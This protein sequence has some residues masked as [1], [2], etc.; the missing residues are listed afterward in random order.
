MP[1]KAVRS[2]LPFRLGRGIIYVLPLRSLAYAAIS[3]AIVAAVLLAIDRLVLGS[4]ERGGWTAGELW[5]RH[6]RL[7]EENTRRKTTSNECALRH[8]NGHPLAATSG[9]SRRRILVIGDSFVWGPAY[10]TLNHLWWRQLAIELERRGYRDVEV[11]AVG[12][13]GWSTRRQLDCARQT[14]PAVK[15]DLVIWG[16]V[17]NDPD[18]KLIPQIFDLQN[19][20][21]I[22]DRV[23]R[24]LKWALPN[25][26]FKFESLRADKL[27]QQYAGPKYG[28]LYPD[29]ELQLLQGENFVRYRHTVNE[30][31]QFLRDSNVPAFLLTLPSLP[32]REYFEPRYAP[33]LPIWREAGV[34]VHNTLDEFI[35]RYGNVPEKGPEALAWGVNPADS[36]PGPRATH[37]HAARAADFIEQHWPHALGPKDPSRE[38][39]LAINDWL[40]H[41]LNV[42]QT[43][44]ATFLLDYPATTEFMPRLP[45][46][47]PTALVALRYPLPVSEI[48]IS[49]DGL[50]SG[51][52]WISTLHPTEHYDESQWREL[53]RWKGETHIFRLPA[54][55]ASRALT[56]VRF[57]ADVAGGDREL[58]LTLV[59]TVAGKERP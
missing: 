30:G 47:E 38:H 4:L 56:A 28:Y 3:G 6:I 49:G 59:R 45:L 41:D 58:R 7:I 36:H 24:R 54:D 35:G 53:G 12:H 5:T 26:L 2:L 32:C 55:L 34:T 27:A 10:L 39:E 17:T 15:P 51:R 31:S 1:Q 8:W 9:T 33:V 11:F 13:P 44:E 25:L 43:G 21:P 29:W 18:E 37:F 52:L 22:P 20:S 23:R 16:Y 46:D 14:I 50:T 40:P 48:K 42:R 57:S 19:D